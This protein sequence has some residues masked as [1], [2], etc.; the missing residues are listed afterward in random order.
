MSQSSSPYSKATV[1]LVLLAAG[2]SKR[3][4]SPKQLLK[5][6]SNSLIY[7]MTKKAL[8]SSCF[9]VVI[10]L[11]ASK[12]LVISEIENLPVFVTENPDWESGMS[13][14]IKIGIREML[15]VY[16]PVKAGIIMVIDQ[17]HITTPL[18]N[19]LV[20]AHKTN[21]T[22][23][24]IASTYEG[25]CGT[26]VLFD[27]KWFVQLL[28][29]KGDKGAKALITNCPPSEL[30]TINFVKGEVELDTLEDYLLFQQES[31]LSTEL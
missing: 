4:G 27:K 30:S 14:S 7:H 6:G 12:S 20:D 25:A 19:E 29:L 22:K 5:I 3:M 2:E 1:G 23:S 9:P 13:S 21:A 10:V 15:R 17:P 18:I 31:G 8:R 26:P 24:I 16:P 28:K 11:G